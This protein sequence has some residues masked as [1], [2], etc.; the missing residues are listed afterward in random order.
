MKASSRHLKTNIKELENGLETIKNLTPVSYDY[1]SD[2]IEGNTSGDIGFIAE[3]SPSISVNEGKAI[4]VQKLA[5]WA[6]LGIKELIEENNKLKDEVLNL[7]IKFDDL[8]EE[9]N[10]SGTKKHV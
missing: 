7:K 5:T 9:L 4:S 2:L 1:I 10:S 6:I 3:D 8:S